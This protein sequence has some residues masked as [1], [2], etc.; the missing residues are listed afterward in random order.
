MITAFNFPVAV[1]SWN[2][3]LAL[4]CG[5][6]V[7]WKPSPRTP[8]TALACQALLRRAGERIGGIPDGLLEV[9]VGGNERAEQLADDPRVPLVSATG[10]TVMGRALAPAWRRGSAAACSSW[11]ATTR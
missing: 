8:L 4:V 10:S 7:I 1:W 6:S 11:A 5:D 2:T 9:V 3:A